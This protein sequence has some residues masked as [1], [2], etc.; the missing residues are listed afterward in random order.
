MSPALWAF[1]GDLQLQDPQMGAIVLDPLIENMKGQRTDIFLIQ[2]S[3]A[4]V[5]LAGLSRSPK[6]SSRNELSFSD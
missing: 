1:L 5:K 3:Y 4:Q 2:V 6:S